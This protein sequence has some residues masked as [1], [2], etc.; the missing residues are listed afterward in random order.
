MS[1]DSPYDVPGHSLQEPTAIAESGLSPD[2]VEIR[3]PA[4]PQHLS[5]VRA[6]AAD[7]AMHQDMDLDS[8]DDLRLAVDEACS[9]LVRLAAEGRTLTCRFTVLPVEIKVNVWVHSANNAGPSTRGFSWQVLQTLT[10]TAISEVAK[11][12]TDYLVRIQLVK[13]KPDHR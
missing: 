8:V 7:L 13:R 5:V 2:T 4:T 12:G 9:S 3:V 10:D 11:E 1:T 6:V